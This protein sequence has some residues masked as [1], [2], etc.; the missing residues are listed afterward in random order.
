MLGTYHRLHIPV[1]ASDITV[2]RAA[3]KKIS[4][5]HLH[6]RKHRDARHS[7]YRVML[8]YHRKAQQLFYAARI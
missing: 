3:R 1:W 6:S 7:F 4:K 2:I 5:S 8:N